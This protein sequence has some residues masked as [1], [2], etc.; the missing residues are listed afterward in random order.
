MAFNIR[1]FRNSFRN[2]EP[3]SPAYYQVA[4][5][6]N[7]NNIRK[8]NAN[9]SL[10]RQQDLSVE[11]TSIKYRCLS[12]TLPGKALNTVERRTYGPTRKIATG[13]VYQDV[14]CSFVISDD[15]TELEYFNSWMGVISN[16]AN[17]QNSIV[18]D[19]AYYSKYVA[20]V[21]IYQYSKSGAVSRV[22]V[23]E[24]AYPINIGDI[25]LAW[26]MSNEIMR[27]DITFAYRTWRSIDGQNT[28]G[29]DA[30]A[31]YYIK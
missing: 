26:D 3:A 17:Y 28:L 18:N 30:P 7:P 27:V 23:L 29:Q 14:I 8:V 12:A 11:Q 24:E 25:Q 19:V 15:M 13:S 21:Y 16:N 5:I 31:K 20:N 6:R 4:I 1:D 10:P 2:G 22:V 9:N